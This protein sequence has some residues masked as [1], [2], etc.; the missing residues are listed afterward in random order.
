MHQEGAVSETRKTRTAFLTGGTGFVGSNLARALVDE[1]W[2][3]LALQRASST[4]D[5]LRGLDV[6]MVEGDLTQ[7]DSL[8][9]AMPEGVDAVFHVAGSINMWSRRNAEQAAIN[10][11][12][13]RNLAAAALRRGASI[14]I[15]T[16]TIS[17]FGPQ[18][19][20]ITEE[21]V[22]NAPA[23]TVNYERTKWQ[24]EQEIRRV[25][26]Q[27]LRAVIIN[28]C[29]ILGPG[30]THG[31]AQFFSMLKEGKL[32]GIP[33]GRL[34]VND[35]REVAK[36][37]ISA[38]HRGRAGAN[39]LLGGEDTT[40]ENLLR[41]MAELLEMEL[42]ARVMPAP[43]LKLIARIQGMVSAVTGK[44]P[45]L[46]SEMATMMCQEVICGSDRAEREL[47]Y[48]PVPMRQSLA[49]SLQWLREHRLL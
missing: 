27:G 12:G 39:Y 16:S 25:T 2:R 20:P 15:H 47:E 43:V 40:F 45:E 8:L 3:V 9:A 44:P 37:H 38:V 30:D 17:A 34:T 22:S 6:D 29:A 10:V 42:R 33:P 49:D 35:V 24:A 41:T 13:T 32:K 28:P 36:A 14:F 7:P 11:G 5:K 23:S 48:R 18:S 31:W 1:G 26:E 21:T 19:G 4:T 46:S